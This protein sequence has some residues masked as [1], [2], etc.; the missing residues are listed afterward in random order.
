MIRSLAIEQANSE[1]LGLITKA[2]FKNGSQSAQL[3]SNFEARNGKTICTKM[4]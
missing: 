3:K 4:V 1:G 2:I